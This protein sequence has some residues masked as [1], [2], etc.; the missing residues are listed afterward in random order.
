MDYKKLGL[1]VGLEIHQQLAS[2]TKLFCRCPIMKSEEFP[3]EIHRKMRPVQSELGEE[4]PAALFEYLRNRTFVYK[5]NPESSCLIELDES[6][7]L[8]MNESALKIAIQLSKLLHC[9]LVDEI[10]VMRKTVIDG[11]AVTGFQRTSLIATDGY[12]ETSFGQLDIQTINI[13]E[14]SAPAV[15]RGENIEYRLDRLGIPLVEIATGSTIGS[16]EQAKEAA[17]KIGSLLR[18]LDV[19]RG[20]GSIRQD[21]N[22]SIKEGSRVEI[23]G[24]QQLEDIPALVENEVA[25]QTS[26]IEIK[27]ELRKRGFHEI[28]PETMDVTKIFQKTQCNFVRKA[29]ESGQHVFALVLPKFSGLLKKQCGDRTFGKELSAYPGAYGFGITHSDEDLEKYKLT[30]EFVELRKEFGAKTEDIVL[31]VVGNNSSRAISALVNRINYCIIGVPNETRLADGIGSKYGRPLPGSGRLYPESDVPAISTIRFRNIEVPKTLEERKK[32]L[33]IPE[34][35]AEQIVKSKYYNW[36]N[37]LKEY[38]PILAATIFLSTYKDLSRRGFEVSKITKE[39]LGTL[40]KN[41]SEGDIPKSAIMPILEAL[42]AGTSIDSAM[43][44]Y[45]RLPDEQLKALV[46]ST[47]KENSE[48]SDSA[49]IGIILSK[50]KGKADGKKVAELVKELR[51]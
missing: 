10:Y 49:L 27:E 26:L 44:V 18:G 5:F 1:R 45:Y 35:L 17:E 19:V 34:Q 30:N 33:K 47:I 7:P 28:K 50:A 36:Y 16:P 43:S 22:I 51:K 29:I 37:E 23:K 11:S 4:D 14:D 21:V 42:C 2:G 9:N 3:L 15:G 12:I 6:P 13:E 20:I 38:D 46:Q 24:F 39:S 41:I 32:E 25:R 48:K 8:S 31:I 40:L